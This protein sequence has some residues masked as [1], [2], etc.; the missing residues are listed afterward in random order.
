MGW[1]KVKR[2]WHK[3]IREFFNGKKLRGLTMVEAQWEKKSE[4]T[5]ALKTTIRNKIKQPRRPP[6]SGTTTEVRKTITTSR[7]KFG[8]KVKENEKRERGKKDRRE[9]GA[10]ILCSKP[11]RELPNRKKNKQKEWSSNDRLGAT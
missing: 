1:S 2:P 6:K 3:Q 11:K 10:E 4:K 5:Y 9:Q 7:K 8:E